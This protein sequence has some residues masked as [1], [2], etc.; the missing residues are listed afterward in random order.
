MMR[1]S[2][3]ESRARAGFSLLESL[4]VCAIVAVLLG[5]LLPALLRARESARTAA[6]AS[7]IRQLSTANRAFAGDHRGDLAP[8][9]SDFRENLHRWH[10]SR[11][12]VYEPFVP[13]GGA[14][15]PYLGGDGLVRSCPSF[16]RVSREPGV[17]FEAGAGGYGYNMAYLGV[18]LDLDDAIGAPLS[19]ITAPAR[20]VE[21]ADTAFVLVMPTTHL[22]E[23]SFVEPPRARS[24]PDAWLDPSTHFRHGGAA[25]VV[26]A[27]GH[28]DG[29][30][31]AHT[32]GNL[33]G[34]SAEEH[35]RLEVGWFG[36]ESNEWFDLR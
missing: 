2:L 28:V 24:Q 35:R 1:R 32:R 29:R 36:P 20:T 30:T 26:W 18:G 15:T 5:L 16:E 25:S 12:S 9:A 13:E 14:L 27:D 3:V 34:A 8:G 7:N 10:G 31:L 19:A 4:M 22:A 17:D 23:Y 21:F 33:Y 11:S 6:C